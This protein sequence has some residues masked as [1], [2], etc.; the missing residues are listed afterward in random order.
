MV[1]DLLDYSEYVESHAVIVFLDLYRA[2]DTV[3]HPFIYK[4]LELLFGENLISV[5][6]MLH[7]DINSNVM[8]YPN[9]SKRFPVNRSV[10]QG[11]PIS[12]FLFLIVAELFSL[13]I[14]NSLNINGLSIFQREIHITQLADDTVLFL[15]DKHQIEPAIQLVNKFSKASAQHLNIGKCE[16]F[17]LI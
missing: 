12:P 8:T 5:V 17:V 11:C 15:K 16:N 6:K 13:T 1:L 10:R 14:L 7:K 4:V 2:F 3:E 9:T